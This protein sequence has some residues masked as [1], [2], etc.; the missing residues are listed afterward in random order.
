MD[1]ITQVAYSSGPTVSYTYNGDGFITARTDA[2]GSTS[3]TPDGLNR[4][5]AETD[6]GNVKFSYTYDDASNMTSF[7]DA[8]GT[9]TYSYNGLNELVSMYE[10]GGKC[11]SPASL[12]TTFG[13]DN[14][15]RLTKVTYPSGVSENYTLDPAT[16]RVTSIVAKSPSGATLKSDAYTYTHAGNDTV[17]IQAVT[18]QAGNVTSY[19]YDPL[20]RVTDA[21]TTGA[22]PSR[23]HYDLDGDGNRTDQIVNTSGSSGGTTTYYTLNA[24]NQLLCRQTV[25]GSCTANSASELSGYSYDGAGNETAINP[26]ADSSKTLFGYNTA[27]QLTGLTPPGASLQTLKYLGSGQDAL[28]NIGS[29][30]IQNSLLGVTDQ[31]DSSGTSYFARTPAGALVDERAPSGRYNPLFDAQ[32]SIIGL[33]NTSGS[34]VRDFTY[35]PYGENTKSTG[36]QTVPAPFGFQGGYRMAGGNAGAGNVSNGLYHFGQRFYDPTVGRWTQQDPLDQLGDPVQADRYVFAGGDPVNLADPGGMSLLGDIAHNFEY[37]GSRVVRNA[38][39]GGIGGAAFATVNGAPEAAPEA[40][41]GGGVE[42]V[43]DGLT[44]GVA[45][46]YNRRFGEHADESLQLRS[47]FTHIWSGR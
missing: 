9:T 39:A 1:R 27:N 21:V 46:L 44:S 43:G 47:Y 42:G 38:V 5:T 16:G 8:G 10:P 29:T 20:D 7:T 34:V 6:P 2:T 28:V 14:D 35:G 3:Y 19:T 18:D 12:C 33:T 36:T 22:S 31:A 23:Y 4:L 25:S 11:T 15:A 30:A 17:L 40:A 26:F 37:V 13:Y 45:G 32:G 41:I 24:G